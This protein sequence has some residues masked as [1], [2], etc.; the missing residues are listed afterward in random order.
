MKNL[1]RTLMMATALSAGLAGQAFAD[2][3]DI[4][5]SGAWTAYAGT[6]DTGKPM[7]GMAIKG[8]DKTLHIKW[9]QGWPDYGIFAW[10][11]GWRTPEGAKLSVSLGFDKKPLGDATATG[12]QTKAEHRAY[13]GDYI[14]FSVGPE[15]IDEFM[16]EFAEAD[17][18][19]LRFNS[20]N[21]TPWFADMKG[22]RSIAAAFSKCVKAL[23]VEPTQPYGKQ[24]EAGTQ[25][26]NRDKL[27]TPTQDRGA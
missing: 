9:G 20:G 26:F 4:A 25:P 6:S 21:E 15:K 19:W 14:Q 2:T 8:S 22:S 7:C 24:P 12:F 23:S 10:K 11:Q 27:P 1:V 17:K 18:M 3:K 5:K 16:S 13:L